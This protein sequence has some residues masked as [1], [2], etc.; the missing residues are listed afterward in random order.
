MAKSIKANYIYNIAN[1][2]LG[3][4]FPLI[5]F[6]YISRVLQPDGVGLYNFYN[7]IITYVGLFANIGIPLYATRKIA[8]HRN[9]VKQRSQLTIEIFL[10][11]I[12]TTFIAYISVFILDAFIPRIHKNYELFYVMSLSVILGPLSVNWFFQALED[13]KYM[14]LRSLFVKLL[15][16]VLLIIFVR[17]KDDVMAYA[18]IG[19]IASI[20]NNLFN[21]VHLHKFIQAKEV[22]WREL[23]IFRHLKFCLM[24]FVL[25]IA[26]SIYVNLDSVMLGFIQN[27]EAVGYYSVAGRISHI[28]LSLITA[29]GTVLLPRFS[30]LLESGKI[31]D[32]N[33]LCR[34]SMDFTIGISLPIVIGLILFS[35]PLV[36]LLL[37]SQYK[38]SVLVLQI[39]A[40]IILLAGITN[41]LGIQIL[42]PKG[43]DLLVICSTVGAAIINFTLNLVLIPYYSYNGAAFSTCIAEL[44]VLLIQL[45]IGRYFLPS[46]L[47]NSKS[48][49]DY[50]IC[51]SVMGIV[52]LLILNLNMPLWIELSLGIICGALIYLFALVCRKNELAIEIIELVKNRIK[53][54]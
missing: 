33:R 11:N 49:I 23:S 35:Y 43:K 50:L 12:F 2:F 52:I 14:T 17:E 54:I 8:Q 21:F 24:L 18:V 36:V 26:V 3:L 10:L 47:F 40:P 13:F 39:I 38:E 9:D 53:W 19:L 27:D 28:I 29:L 25:N 41:V 44:A 37:G 15:S 1:T 34:K 45:W 51:S 4:I 7:S 42:Y 22:K 30:Y 46:K 20:G 6:P 48:I 32:F 5:T 31:E 16:L